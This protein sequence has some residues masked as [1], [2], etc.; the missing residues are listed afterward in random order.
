SATVSSGATVLS[1]SRMTALPDAA[2][3]LPAA[4]PTDSDEAIEASRSEER[5]AG[6]VARPGSA[7]TTLWLP[8]LNVAVPVSSSSPPTVNETLYASD[9]LIA[10]SAVSATV[11]SGDTVLSVSRMT[12]LPDAAKPLPAGSPTDSDEAIEAS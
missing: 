10:L 11:S 4:S 3:P 6:K 5:R 8:S 7:A 12:T 2:K 1:V 9:L